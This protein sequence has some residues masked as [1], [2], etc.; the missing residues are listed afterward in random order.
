[1][2]VITP[3][4]SHYS[5]LGISWLS[6]VDCRRAASDHGNWPD[7]LD[8]RCWITTRKFACMRLPSL[9]EEVEVCHRTCSADLSR[10]GSTDVCSQGQFRTRPVNDS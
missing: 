7:G 10:H 3:L 8:F 1:M 4:K 6:Q 5:D 2:I 9:L